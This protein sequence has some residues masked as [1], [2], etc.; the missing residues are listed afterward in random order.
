MLGKLLK[1]E[2]RFSS[3]WKFSQSTDF[4]LYLT[5]IRMIFRKPKGLSKVTLKIDLKTDK[6]DLTVA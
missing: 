1:F 6:S 4:N 5:L 3:L 2:L